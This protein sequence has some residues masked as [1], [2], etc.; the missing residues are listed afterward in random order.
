MKS[1]TGAGAN[2]MA[3]RSG[4][5]AQPK[6]DAIDIVYLWVDGADPVWQAKRQ[7]AYAAWVQHNPDELAMFGNSAGRYRDNDELLFNLRSLE[8]FYPDHG[9]IY[10]V[11]DAQVPAWLQPSDR[12]SIIDH[13]SL[14]PSADVLAFDSGHIESYLHHIPG[15]SE[16]FFYLNDDVFFGADVDVAW[17][18]GDCLKVFAEASCIPDYTE[19]QRDKTAPVNASIAAKKWLSRRYPGYQHDARLYSHSP[20]PMLKSVMH[21][22]EALAPELF[23]QVRSTTFRSWRIPAIVPDLVPR[24]MVQMGYAEQHVLNPLYIG[25]GDRRAEQQLQ[26]LQVKFGSLPF[27]CINDTCDDAEADDLR[28]LR[29][30]RTLKKILPEPSSF[31]KSNRQGQAKRT[32]A[33]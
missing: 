5:P 7:R 15:L 29:I 24:W 22:L 3:T 19:L 12:L 28:L 25:S 30:G 33:A 6:P 4:K 26:A 13:R 16:R 27:F 14:L 20:R 1:T 17:W 2:L 8:K 23:A 18:F 21:A 31:E 11:T 10:I 32:A 9:H